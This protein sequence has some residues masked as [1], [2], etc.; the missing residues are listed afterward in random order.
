MAEDAKPRLL[1]VDDSR[2]MRTAGKKM[3]GDRFD[4]IV[5]ED[6]VDGWEKICADQS[7]QVVFSDLS[8]PNM[9]GYQL[10]AKIRGSDDA[11]ISGMPVIIV[12]G[13]ENDEQAREKALQQGATDFITK[14]FNSTDITARATAHANYQRERRRLEQQTTLDELTGLGNARFLETRLRQEL[15]F[16]QRHG[17]QL[18]LLEVEMDDFNSLFLKLG[19]AS[20]DHL[21]KQ[22]GQVVAKLARKEDTAARVGLAR[23]VLLLPCADSEGAKL[24]AERLFAQLGRLAPTLQGKPFPLTVS[25]GVISPESHPGQTARSVLDELGT[26]MKALRQAGGNRVLR[27]EELRQAD[28]SLLPSVPEA[29]P[30]EEKEVRLSVDQALQALARGDRKTVI[31]ALPWLKRQLAPLVTLMTEEKRKA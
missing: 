27:D 6:G 29:P 19:K 26:I 1:L 14:P 9:D 16:A 4:V 11:G 8:M 30:V 31:A 17:H 28:G 23:F 7:I 10:L 22:V 24:F 12:T 15:A 2:V 18:S 21:L 25:L 3:L 5:A 20:A 13:A